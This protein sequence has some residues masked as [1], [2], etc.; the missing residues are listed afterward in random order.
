MR[1]DRLQ[2]GQLHQVTDSAGLNALPD[3][4]VVLETLPVTNQ[5]EGA[6]Y[7]VTFPDKAKQYAAVGASFGQDLQ[8]ALAGQRGM[9][10]DSMSELH[11]KS[12]SSTLGHIAEHRVSFLA[13][14]FCS[15]RKSYLQHQ[16]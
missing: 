10:K 7:T 6:L 13:V 9:L 12:R 11:G 16:K 2:C 15:E 1:N 3:N 4:A 8:A 14:L 5:P